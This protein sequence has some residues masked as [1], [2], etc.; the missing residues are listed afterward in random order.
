MIPMP[1][2]AANGS[3]EFP[4]GNEAGEWGSVVGL[5]GRLLGG[6]QLV[7]QRR[8]R[9]CLVCHRLLLGSPAVTL[10]TVLED[11]QTQ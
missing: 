5:L 3:I 9:W 11:F 7:S 10:E 8:S 6:L 1:T 4:G 2:R